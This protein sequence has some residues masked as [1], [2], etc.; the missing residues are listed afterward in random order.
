MSEVLYHYCATATAEAIISGKSVRLSALD[1]ANDTMEGQWALEQLCQKLGQR[2]VPLAVIS[3]IRDISTVQM[4]QSLVLGFCLSKKPD[5][6]SQWRGYADN[7]RGLAIGFS[8]TELARS[9]ITF[10]A[11]LIGTKLIDVIY[12]VGQSHIA[13]QSE[14][15]LEIHRRGSLASQLS[16]WREFEASQADDVTQLINLQIFPVFL[17][18]VLTAYNLKNS[19]FQEEQECRLITEVGLAGPIRA[20]PASTIR[21]CEFRATGAKLIPFLS[22]PLQPGAIVEVVVGPQHETPVGLVKARL[23]VAGF[24]VEVS[25]SKATYKSAI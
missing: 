11:G 18:I 14:R 1:L 6:L 24:D 25:K 13:A 20:S 15:I 23:R 3:S 9:I 4:S 12:D 17:D 2:G 10:D 19:A 16:I 7:G 22:L 8:R 5:V 21:S